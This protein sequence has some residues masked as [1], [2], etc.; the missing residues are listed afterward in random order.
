MRVTRAA[1]R[2]QQDAEEPVEAVEAKNRALQDIEPNAPHSE[3]SEDP[4]PLKTPA[5]TPAKKGKAKGAKKG[6]KGRKAK[7]DEEDLAQTVEEARQQVTVDLDLEHE[8]LGGKW[9]GYH[10][11]VTSRDQSIIVCR[12]R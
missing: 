12:C 8:H 6:A 4:L 1:Q 2:A 11:S 10:S 9:L 5:K 7:T 3:Q